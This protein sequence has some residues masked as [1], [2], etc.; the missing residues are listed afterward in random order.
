MP[1]KDE[2]GNDVF[3]E[4]YDYKEGKVV[5]VNATTFRKE[6]EQ[7]TA[8]NIS[9]SLGDLKEVLGLNVTGEDAETK[10]NIKLS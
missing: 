6:Y 7:L 5:K 8:D 10:I 2:D 4:Y 1:L 9:K 3:F